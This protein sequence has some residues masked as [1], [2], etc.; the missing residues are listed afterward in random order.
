MFLRNVWFP[1]K[2]KAPEARGYA[3]QLDS[4]VRAA[5][6]RVLQVVTAKFRTYA[7]FWA[8]KTTAARNEESATLHKGT[9]YNTNF[10]VACT[11]RY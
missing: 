2:C 5:C 7:I 9:R 4:R 1:P 10:V 8:P 6:L 11:E 3:V